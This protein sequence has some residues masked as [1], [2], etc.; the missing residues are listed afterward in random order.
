M[1]AMV[2]VNIDWV[3]FNTVLALMLNLVYTLGSVR[4]RHNY[5]IVLYN[6]III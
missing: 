1:I 4:E 6:N 3:A 2:L 5:I